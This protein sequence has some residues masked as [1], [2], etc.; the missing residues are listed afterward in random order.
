MRLAFALS[1]FALAG[2]W[3]L[4]PALRLRRGQPGDGHDHQ[5]APHGPAT[6]A[7]QK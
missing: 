1:L 2:G 5:T 7:G 6:Q 4:R 3:R